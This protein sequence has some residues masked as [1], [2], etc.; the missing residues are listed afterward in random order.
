MAA[1][2]N[3]RRE[4]LRDFCEAF[5]EYYEVNKPDELPTLNCDLEIKNPALLDMA[6]VESLNSLEP[7]GSGNPKPTMM[8]SGARLERIMPI[9]GGK[10][11]RLGVSYKD[12]SFECVFFSHTEE[13]LK[14]NIGDCV[15]IAFTPQINEYRFKSV[16]L[17][18]IAIRRHDPKPLCS[19]LLDLSDEL[20]VSEAS[21]YCPD[22][23]AFVRVWRKLQ[24]V[25]GSVAPDFDGVM[26][27]CPGGV[28]PERFCIC[29]LVLCELGL[30][31][32]CRPNS[33]FGA[34]IVSGG[35]KVNL[36]D[37]KLI[38]RLKA[39]F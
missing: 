2:L 16:Q 36:E 29:L 38:K 18:L 5:S 34:K 22:R 10:H 3:I 23:S 27:Q 30:L 4:K 11:L 32:K 26:R 15:D 31:S 14:L 9:G 20:P 19:R 24:S 35:A 8:I 6:G 33:L 39:R 37:S 17:Q 21:G 25:G 7:Y 13:E 28:E 1:G 12:C